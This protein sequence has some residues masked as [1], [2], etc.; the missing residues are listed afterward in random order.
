MSKKGLTGLSL[1]GNR[2]QLNFDFKRLN[3]F[4][5]PWQYATIQL[6]YIFHLFIAEFF[7]NI[8]YRWHFRAHNHF[9]INWQ[10]LK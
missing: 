10:H 3:C 7:C 1:K 9:V 5:I 4:L 8:K 2:N 6:Q